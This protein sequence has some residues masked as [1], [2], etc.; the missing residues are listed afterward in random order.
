MK[1][2]NF[3]LNNEDIIMSFLEI[4][5][6]QPNESHT[7]NK[8]TKSAKTAIKVDSVKNCPI[9]AFFSEPK[10]LRIPTYFALPE[11]LAVVR[12]MKL[13]QAINKINSAAAEK[14]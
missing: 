1:I 9:S 11:D 13:I 8:L 5:L 6:N 2:K 14:I 10:T 12:F 3:G 4:P 7:N